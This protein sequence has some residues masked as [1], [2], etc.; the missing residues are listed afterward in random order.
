MSTWISFAFVVFR[1][2]IRVR[3]FGNLQLDDFLVVAA[4][5]MLLA[6]AIVW[7][8]KIYFVYELYDV[9]AG[10]TPPVSF[11]TDYKSFMPNIIT[12]N[13]L[14]YSSLW[15]IKFSF[16]I[17]FRRLGSKVKSHIIWW[18]VVLGLAVIGYIVC[19][20]DIDWDCSLKSVA[21]ITSGSS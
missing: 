10:K 3:A 17:F 20:A 11:L 18:W 14:F 7:H 6:A 8:Y 16:L 19:V 13:V 12:W 4:W 9:L 15:S 1:L 2:I 5:F 21:Y